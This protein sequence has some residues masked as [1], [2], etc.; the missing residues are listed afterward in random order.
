MSEEG[1]GGVPCY[2]PLL[3]A[4]PFRAVIPAVLIDVLFFL[5]V[6]QVSVGEF[7]RYVAPR[8]M[9]SHRDKR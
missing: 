3:P 5:F 4:S 7:G 6:E 1:K 8:S 2:S 9:K